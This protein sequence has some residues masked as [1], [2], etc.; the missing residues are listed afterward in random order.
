MALI[1]D[2]TGVVTTAS[3]AKPMLCHYCRE[4]KLGPFT[5]SPENK[6]TCADCAA[7]MGKPII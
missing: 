6:P 2:K 5:V 7:K 1:V 3:M 4:R